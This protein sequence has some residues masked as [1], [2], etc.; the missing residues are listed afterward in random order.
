MVVVVCLVQVKYVRHF[1]AL[2]Q[3]EAAIID[4]IISL[5]STPDM[6]DLGF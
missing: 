3:D 6:V 1:W 2:Q 5:L 4:G